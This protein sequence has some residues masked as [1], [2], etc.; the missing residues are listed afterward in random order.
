MASRRAYS[1]G[2]VAPHAEA[3][4]AA[5]DLQ[6]SLL[7][8]AHGQPRPPLAPSSCLAAVRRRGVAGRR[9]CMADE[10]PARPHRAR[11]APASSQSARSARSLGL[12]TC[13]FAVRGLGASSGPGEP[14]GTIYSSRV[15]QCSEACYR[16][17]ARVRTPR[18]TCSGDAG[19]AHSV[20]EHAQ[21]GR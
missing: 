8:F 21:G 14:H 4:A 5:A 12:G 3:A 6:Q 16:T 13:S 2:I 9:G 18:G 15:R 20:P 7:S 19:H 17:P 1:R 11:S 10:V